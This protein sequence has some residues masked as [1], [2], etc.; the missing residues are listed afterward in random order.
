MA[1]LDV[2]GFPEDKQMLVGDSE[3]GCWIFSALDAFRGCVV[4]NLYYVFGEDELGTN[5]H[6]EDRK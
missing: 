5:E 4:L 1:I 2:S 6:L 3:K